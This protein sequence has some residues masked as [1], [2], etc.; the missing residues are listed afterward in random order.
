MVARWR[1]LPL[2]ALWCGQGWGWGR[3]T[4]ATQPHI[5]TERDRRSSARAGSQAGRSA[6]QL[7]EEMR[8][9]CVAVLRHLPDHQGTSSFLQSKRAGCTHREACPQCLHPRPVDNTACFSPVACPLRSRSSSISRELRTCQAK[10]RS[11]DIAALQP[12]PGPPAHLT[13][14]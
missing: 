2:P 8:L 7:V 1:A 10:L 11:S 13:G 14:P 5:H 9:R 3:R 4:L 12:M 6:G